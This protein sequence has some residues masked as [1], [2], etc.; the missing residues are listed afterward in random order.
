MRRG[1]QEP[2]VAEVKAAKRHGNKKS[3]RFLI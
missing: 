1:F 3:Q 2:T